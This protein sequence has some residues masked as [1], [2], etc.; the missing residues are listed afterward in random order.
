MI[1]HRKINRERM[2]ALFLLGVLAFN[3]PLLLLF[4]RLVMPMMSMVNEL[5]YATFLAPRYEEAT[6]RLEETTQNLQQLNRAAAG[7]RGE[8]VDTDTEDG[9]DGIWSATRQWWRAWMGRW[10]KR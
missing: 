4:A 10:T 7:A 8:A 6:G 9:E 2:V 3:A 1:R 5:I